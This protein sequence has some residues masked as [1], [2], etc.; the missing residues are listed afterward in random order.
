[1]NTIIL[2]K[3][4]KVKAWYFGLYNDIELAEIWE[5]HPSLLEGLFSAWEKRVTEEG[6]ELNNPKI[7]LK[8]V[9]MGKLVYP[10]KPVLDTIFE[11]KTRSRSKKV[12]DRQS[13]SPS[14]E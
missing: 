6:I 1:M 12:P 7:S 13:H 2:N 11:P 5:V 9:R 8:L 3:Y 14:L 4:R 10:A